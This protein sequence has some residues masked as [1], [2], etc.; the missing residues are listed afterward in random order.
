MP[1]FED[2]DEAEAWAAMRAAFAD[3]DSAAKV[4]PDEAAAMA[5]VREAFGEDAAPAFAPAPAAR[6]SKSSA[7]KGAASGGS[8]PSASPPSA[9]A[10][11]RRE[12]NSGETDTWLQG[13]VDQLVGEVQRIAR[14]PFPRDLLFMLW[15]LPLEDQQEVLLGA[16]GTVSDMIADKAAKAK[17]LWA[18]IEEEARARGSSLPS[19]VAATLAKKSTATPA[20]PKGRGA[21]PSAP[22][23]FDGGAR[24]RSRSPSL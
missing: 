17:K 22:G 6:P 3:D 7:D 4:D 23:D 14:G 18:L 5:A 15:N 1:E 10:E 12:T 13:Q 2:P 20:P 19:A 9:A 16:S 24:S 8:K 11:K 21:A